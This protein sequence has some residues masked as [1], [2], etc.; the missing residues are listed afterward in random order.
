MQLN[1]TLFFVFFPPNTRKGAEKNKTKY[2][3]HLCMNYAFFGGK[4]L[5]E[6]DLKR[7]VLD[8]IKTKRKRINLTV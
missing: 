7:L 5:Q 1:T 4:Y 8:K 3:W 6:S 2:F